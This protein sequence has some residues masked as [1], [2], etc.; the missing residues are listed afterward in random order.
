[1]KNLHLSEE[2]LKLL[3]E[4]QTGD[5]W[6]FFPS[7]LTSEDYKQIGPIWD[8][9]LAT[10]EVDGGVIERIKRLLPKGPIS[11]E[12]EPMLAGYNCFIA[13]AYVMGYEVRLL[14]KSVG[15]AGTM[16]I[17][18]GMSTISR[19]GFER[20][21]FEEVEAF[22]EKGCKGA[23]FLESTKRPV[24]DHTG[25]YVGSHEGTDLFFHKN[26]RSLPTISTLDALLTASSHIVHRGDQMVAKSVPAYFQKHE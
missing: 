7:S 9:I 5:N 15:E 23:I 24:Y 21:G 3:S 26:W 13:L 17:P 1:M 11:M 10:S 12:E 2:E 19:P 22:T 18:Q 25:V 8:K 6:H 16:V 4:P 14:E 20:S